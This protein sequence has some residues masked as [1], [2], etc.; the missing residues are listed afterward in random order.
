M[1]ENEFEELNVQKKKSGRGLF[2]IGL[3]TGVFSAVLITGIALNAYYGGIIRTD[4]AKFDDAV[5][6]YED[7]IKEMS[8]L[9]EGSAN[10][11]VT[12]EFAEKVGEIYDIIDSIYYFSDKFDVNNT[13][14][15]LYSAILD[16]IDDKYS[17]YYTVEEWAEQKSDSAGTYYGIGSYVSIDT[18]SG[19]PMLSGVFEGS[20]AQAAGLR[21][22]D[23]ITEVEGE[24]VK[25]WELS[26]VVALIRGPENTDVTITILRDSESL[27][28]TV[29]RGEIHTIAVNSEIKRDNI[30]YI[31]ITQF[32]DVASEQFE[33][34]LDKMKSESVKG[35]VIDL[36]SNP[37]GNLS[38]VLEICEQLL[39]KGRITYIEDRFGNKQEYNSTGRHEIKI[40]M[41]V[42]TNEYSASASELM[43]GALRDYEKA[44]IIGTKTFG[45]GI[46]QS[47]YELEDE[48]AVKIT[49]A[50][51]FTPKGECIHGKGIEPDIE[52]EFDSEAYYDETDPVDN[53]LEYAI[54]YLAGKK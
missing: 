43:T 16:S 4:R 45:K 7:R 14:E 12:A 33:K 25:G 10:P 46:V 27:R 48:S 31:Q 41:V 6:Y 54:D 28:V 9:G 13:Q 8:T 18:D 36:R 24:S 52:V 51:Y 40:P 23:L 53:Q 21:D 37:G 49:T 3:L 20:P 19:Y 34:A 30:G 35:I 42:L 38:T 47:L 39:P 26:D 50:S 11:I 2:F 1:D 17:E 32:V 44:T 15:Q 5:T 22:G 29:T